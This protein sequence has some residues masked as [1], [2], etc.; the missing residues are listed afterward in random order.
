MIMLESRF[1]SVQ[2]FSSSFKAFVN[3]KSTEFK[4]KCNQIK[5][6]SFIAYLLFILFG[7]VS[8]TAANGA[9]SESPV[10]TAILPECYKLTS[11]IVIIVQCANIGPLA[12][13]LVWAVV[14]LIWKKTHYLDIA[15]IYCILCFAFITSIFIIIFWSQEVVIYDDVTVSI[16]FFI[17]T[18][19]LAVCDC[20]STVLFLPFVALY[21]T[22]YISALYVG[23]GLSGVLPSLWALVQ[24]S[25]SRECH[26]TGN[27]IKGLR[28]SPTIYFIVITVITTI[29]FIAFTLI[30]FLPLVRR[31]RNHMTTITVFKNSPETENTSETL[32][33]SQRVLQ[34]GEYKTNYV[35]LVQYICIQVIL[36]AFANS[37]LY[38]I[39]PYFTIPYGSS[40]FLLSINLTLIAVPIGSFL[41]G[42]IKPRATLS[43][44]CMLATYLLICIWLIFLSVLIEPKPLEGSLIGE[45]HVIVLFSLSGLIAG[46]LKVGVGVL[47]KKE[48]GP[49]F[50]LLIA[51]GTQLGSFIGGLV[52]FLLVNYTLIFKV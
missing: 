33:P 38:S 24:G 44:W 20:T 31:E 36:C 27:P 46:Y 10:L 25:A 30:L 4:E 32:V 41:G 15:V 5:S 14:K 6:V 1:S 40:T 48:G 35:A 19:C 49:T 43:L 7:L 23:E 45:L 34:P 39:A 29:S 52:A 17:L 8:W 28:F 2:E 50:L 47:A 3:E 51:L 18:G 21:P 11:Y 16:P 42:V 26:Q 9:L 37:F 12:Y 22:P 13:L